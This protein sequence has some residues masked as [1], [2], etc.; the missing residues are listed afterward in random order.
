GATRG[1]A[2]RHFALVE[3]VHGV[4]HDAEVAARGAQ[5]DALDAEQALLETELVAGVAG[6][7]PR[8]ADHAMAR[9]DDRQRVPAQ[10]LCDRAHRVVPPPR[11]ST[12]AM[13]CSERPT[14]MWPS[15]DGKMRY[16]TRRC[17]R[18]ASRLSSPARDCATA[19]GA[20]TARS[21]RAT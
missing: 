2:V 1:Q 6:E 4:A 8:G 7:A 5:L 16:A 18:S 21:P 12:S 20:G 10:R 17:L 15:G 11:Y 19:S 3:G 9:Y 14:R 13:P